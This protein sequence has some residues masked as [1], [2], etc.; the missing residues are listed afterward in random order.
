MS[1]LI[2]K[3]VT[4]FNGHGEAVKGRIIADNLDGTYTVSA[5]DNMVYYVTSEQVLEKQEDKTTKLLYTGAKN[6]VHTYKKFVVT[7]HGYVTTVRNAHQYASLV[8]TC[9]NAG[10]SFTNF[11]VFNI[12]GIYL[13]AFNVEYANRNKIKRQLK[14]LA[15]DYDFRKLSTSDKAEISD[16]LTIK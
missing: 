14:C 5:E 12:D 15:M 16:K 4:V 10:K 8:F 11:Q 7:K 2:G 3:T 1:D 6:L 13:Y 9:E